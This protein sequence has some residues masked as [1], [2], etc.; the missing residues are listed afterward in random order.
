M[1]IDEKTCRFAL[2]ILSTL[3]VNFVLI[4]FNFFSDFKF[5]LQY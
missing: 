2:G 1:K 5:E 3:G 4:F